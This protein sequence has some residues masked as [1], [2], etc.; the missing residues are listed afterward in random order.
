MFSAQLEKSKAATDLANIRSG[1]ADLVS[2][3]LTGDI[4]FGGAASTTAKLKVDGTC[5]TNTSA[6][7][8]KT[9]GDSTHADNNATIGSLKVGTGVTWAKD[10]SITYTITSDGAVTSITGA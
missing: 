10:K 7:E 3:Y 8:Y 5:V 9:K 6:A 2:A 4:A 1:Y